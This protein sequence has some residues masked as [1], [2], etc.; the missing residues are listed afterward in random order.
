SAASFNAN[1]LAQ[2]A[3]VAAFGQRLA[4]TTT[5]ATTTPLP[6]RL[7]GTQVF[8]TDSHMVERPAPLFFVAPGQINYLLPQGT[9]P[10]TAT[11]TV[12]AGDGTLSLGTINVLNVAPAFF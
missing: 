9:A 7:S 11:V 1:A 4:T 10:G 8:V 6:T 3:I 12:T 5:V 2:G